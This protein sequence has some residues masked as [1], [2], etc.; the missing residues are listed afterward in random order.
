MGLLSL[1]SQWG[2]RYKGD[3]VPPLYDAHDPRVCTYFGSSPPENF[4][5][6]PAIFSGDLSEAR[7]SNGGTSGAY[8]HAGVRTSR[9]SR[10]FRSM[11]FSLFG[12]L[13]GEKAFA[14]IITPTSAHG[15]RILFGSLDRDRK[16]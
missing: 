9:T 14:L 3:P 1:I 5:S 2:Q 4:D 7:T 8:M 15:L 13:P 16:R 12:G 10:P 6:L 11:A